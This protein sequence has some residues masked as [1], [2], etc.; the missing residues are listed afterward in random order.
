MS[1]M[2]PV[3]S[4]D[5]WV[6]ADTSHGIF[7]IQ[8]GLVGKTT[9]P[10][11]SALLDY[12]PVSTVEDIYDITLIDGYGARLSATGYMDCTE[13]T[14]FP[15]AVDAATYLRDFYGDGMEDSEYSE[16][17]NEINQAL[18]GFSVQIEG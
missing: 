15:T 2:K 17:V 10:D 4:Y 8:Q 1:F 13:W 16:F 3:I 14:V 18:V 9:S 5:R 6:E 7:F 12:L 11:K